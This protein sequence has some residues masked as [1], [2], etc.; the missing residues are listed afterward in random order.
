MGI[1]LFVS[2]H[3]IKIKVGNS[4]KNEI[5]NPFI[6]PDNRNDEVAVINPAITHKQ[7]AEILASQVSFCIIIGITS[8]IPAIQPK[9]I[10]IKILFML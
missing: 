10:P 9:M 5:S 2:L 3:A 1:I 6:A 8:I 7:N 4:I